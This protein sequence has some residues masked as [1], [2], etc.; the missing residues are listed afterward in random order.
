MAQDGVV[1][2]HGIFRTHRSMAGLARFLEKNG[3][4]TLNIGYPST[5]QAIEHLVDHI[6]PMIEQFAA[7]L[8]GGKLHFV[9]YSMGG[10]VIRAY[11]ARYRPPSLGR[12]VMLGTPNQGSAVAD[13]VCNW[14]LYKKLYGP[15]GQ[16]L[17]TKVDSFR[18]LYGLVDYEVGILAGNRSI[19]IICSIILGREPHDGKVTVKSTELEGMKDHLVIPANH[20]YFPSDKRAWKQTLAFLRDGAFLRD[21]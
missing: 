6:H 13:F 5:R 15:A 12:V 11:L 4:R 18:H 8:E 2:L 20:T 16:Q 9:G 19:D 7:T 1:I 3:Y 10:L 21:N 14:R 17:V